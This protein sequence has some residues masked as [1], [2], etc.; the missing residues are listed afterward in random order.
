MSHAGTFPALEDQ[1]VLFMPFGIEGGGA[2]DGWM[3]GLGAVDLFPRM[4][5]PVP[6]VRG[7][8]RGAAGGGWLL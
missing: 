7:R 5:K 8:M 3:A 2:A 1:M 4:V 6:D